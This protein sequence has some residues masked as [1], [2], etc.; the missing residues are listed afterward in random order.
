MEGHTSM[1][2]VVGAKMSTSPGSDFRLDTPPLEH[3][4]PGRDLDEISKGPCWSPLALRLV[5]V[6]TGGGSGS[7][8]D[9]ILPSRS[10]LSLNS[11]GCRS[12]AFL[13]WHQSLSNRISTVKLTLPIK[14][15]YPSALTAG[16]RP[17]P[18]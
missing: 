12:S 13:P 16:M 9:L 4:W 5:A 2:L 3:H 14:K 11:I 15:L 8:T 17:C 1:L 18:S 10:G 6:R 7:S